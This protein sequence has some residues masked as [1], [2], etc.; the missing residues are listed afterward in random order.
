MHT[1]VP[2]GLTTGT[3]LVLSRSSR[4][5]LIDSRTHFTVF[6]VHFFRSHKRLCFST[7]FQIIDLRPSH[8][9]LSFRGV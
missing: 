7:P 9:D 8:V 5:G 1:G 4:P 6:G 3:C 2:N